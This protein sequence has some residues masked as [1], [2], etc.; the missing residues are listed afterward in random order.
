MRGYVLTLFVGC[1]GRLVEV[2]GGRGRKG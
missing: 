2:G 1:P